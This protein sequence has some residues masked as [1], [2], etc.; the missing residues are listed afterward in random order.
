MNGY[1]ADTH[2]DLI[3]PIHAATRYV[4]PANFTRRNIARTRKKIL[5]GSV[6]KVGVASDPK[7]VGPASKNLEYG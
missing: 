5:K 7:R 3:G 4:T 2:M 6:E 1:T